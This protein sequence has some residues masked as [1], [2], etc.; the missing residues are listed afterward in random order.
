MKV[1]RDFFI[2]SH[3]RKGRK[4]ALGM[5]NL[6]FIFVTISWENVSYSC[7]YG[8]N[9]NLWWISR[10]IPIYRTTNLFELLWSNHLQP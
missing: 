1:T 5:R 10:G 7:H 9:Y 8:S 4:K 2:L 6:Q 3:A